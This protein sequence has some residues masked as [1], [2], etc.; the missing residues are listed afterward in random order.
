MTFPWIRG[1]LWDGVFIWSGAPIGLAL[2]LMPPIAAYWFFAFAILLDT[3]HR[4]S[5]IIL[6]WG[7]SGFRTREV[8][9]HPW[10]YIV[11]PIGILALCVGIAVFMPSYW[12]IL[13]PI[14]WYCNAS[15]FGMQ[16]FGV[17][18]M[19]KRRR[20]RDSVERAADLQICLATMFFAYAILLHS[21][22]RGTVWAFLFIGIISF[23][24]W[25]VA[26][27]LS[28]QAVGEGWLRWA[29][30]PIALAFGA[31]GLFYMMPHEQGITFKA[32]PVIVCAA[33][34]FGFVHFL[35]DGEAWKFHR[36]IVRETIGESLFRQSAARA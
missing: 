2:W 17:L 23:N 22:A 5:P 14:Y 12:K 10:H 9:R 19:Y 28:S 18:S 15:H 13:L 25:L 11:A 8:Y 3:G 20:K 32:L 29:L 36:P 35:Y 27:G 34:G 1:P 7:N 16:N 30:M 31:V 21:M 4:F 26:L 6:A 24:H 33:L